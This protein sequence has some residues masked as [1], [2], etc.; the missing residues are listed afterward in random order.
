MVLTPGY[1]F[2]YR[3]KRPP[4]HNNDIL[5][6][7][8]IYIFHTKNNS[9]GK[10]K[11]KYVVN[12]EEYKHDVFI[13]KFYKQNHSDSKN[14]YSLLTGE[15]LARK[16]IMTCVNIGIHI[17]SQNP[18]ASFGF[19]GMPTLKEIQRP[20]N[21]IYNTKRYRVYEK[22]A[23][24]F[25]QEEN[26]EHNYDIN[27]SAYFMLSIKKRNIDKEIKQKILNMFVDHYTLSNFFSEVMEIE[28]AQ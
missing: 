21:K 2:N 1:D 17:L 26:F 16:I 4:Y 19:L 7:T 18:N 25:F 24:F 22:F 13:L 9:K 6:Y 23:T 27:T 20:A 28:L 11:D 5:V 14:R 8:H 3:T 10:G 12:V 15:F